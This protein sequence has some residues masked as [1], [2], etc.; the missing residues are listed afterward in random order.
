MKLQ[1]KWPVK[2]WWQN[3]LLVLVLL[4][5]PVSWSIGTAMLPANTDPTAARLAEWARDHWLGSVVTAL[6]QLQYEINPPK[7][8]GTITPNS[9]GSTPS[10]T[11]TGEIPIHEALT[12]IVSPSAANEGTFSEAL[13]VGGLPI[14]QVAYLRPDS[15]HTSYVSSVVWMSGAH[16]R[17][18]QRPGTLDPGQLSK[19]STEPVLSRSTPDLIGAFNG[20]F[21]IRSSRGGYYDNGHTQGTLRTG[22]ASIVVYKDGTSNIG[23]WGSDV[24][25]T[26][27]VLSVRQNLDLLVDNDQLAKNINTAVES[28]WGATLKAKTYVWRSGIGITAAGDFVYVMGDALNAY[29][30][31]N[32]LH[33]A[34][35]IRAMQ[36]D[37]NPQWVSFMWFQ[38]SSTG[39][40]VPIK[41]ARFDRPADRYFHP[42]SRDFFA[43]YS[44]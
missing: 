28:N 38:K 25:M 4:L 24:V 39:G 6:E 23:K 7:V 35:A 29:S 40:V 16:V 5:L 33:K 37:I 14:I 26:P 2:K 1:E 12:P 9:F 41:A 27:D 17:F 36:L 21:K 10:A 30:L 31:A 20:G 18:E 34:G 43:I 42:S 3:T 44:K 15:I 22:A 19:W 11:P 13:N 32:L 8:G